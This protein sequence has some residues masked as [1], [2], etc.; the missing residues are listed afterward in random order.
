[1]GSPANTSAS[2]LPSHLAVS[3]GEGLFLRG[4]HE[5]H[6]DP[7]SPILYFLFCVQKDRQDIPQFR[8]RHHA[9]PPLPAQEAKPQTELN[10][11][12]GTIW[13]NIPA[14]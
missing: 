11:I 4:G 2:L 9:F 1:M 7:A 12:L 10:A 6:P 3:Q 8:I 5:L 14:L 13:P